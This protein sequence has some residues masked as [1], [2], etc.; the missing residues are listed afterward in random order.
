MVKRGSSTFSAAAGARSGLALGRSVKKA[1]ALEAEVSRLRH[2]VS[3]LSRRLHLSTLNSES[4]RCELDALRSVA[5]LSRE[6]DG[7]EASPF[8]RRWLM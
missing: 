5:P 8:M 2:H 3:V 6:G 4:L 1:L 7:A